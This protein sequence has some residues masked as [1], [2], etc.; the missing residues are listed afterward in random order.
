MK[1]WFANLSKGL[2]VKVNNTPTEKEGLSTTNSSALTNTYSIT[3]PAEETI[4]TDVLT[5]NYSYPQNKTFFFVDVETATSANDTICAI[6]SI[7]V[8]D[9][10]V[11][12]LYSLINPKTHITNTSIHGIA[13][14]DVHDAPTFDKYWPTI[15]RLIG[16]DFIV[17]GHNVSFDISVIN[18]NLNE[19]GIAFTP[20]MKVDTMAVAK[21]V[22]YNFSTQSG[23]LKLNM[24]CKRLNIS[25]KHHNAESDIAATKQALETLL[26]MGGRSI[27]D[28]I[29]LHHMSR[30]DNVI[31]N[32]KKLS[33][34]RYWEDIH[35]G[36]TPVYFTNWNNTYYDSNPKYDEVELDVLQFASMM[37]R[38]NC[39]IPRVV[40]QV[41]LI[42]SCI[43]S[44]CGKVYGKGAKTAKCYIEFYYMDIA[45]YIKLKKLGYKIYHAID[46]ENFILENK[47]TI[48]QYGEEQTKALTLAMQEK[49]RLARERNE[50]RVQRE[51]RRETKRLEPKE[52]P[53]RNTRRVEQLNDD[54]DVIAVFESI[55][56]AVKTTGTNSKSIRDCCNGIQ[57][58][59]GG[60]VW[61]YLDNDKTN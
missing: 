4:T 27:T 34:N 52:S 13:D 33:P 48:Q 9:G 44:I 59:A 39:N 46:V 6:G 31:G 20:T 28:F 58:H 1:K 51:A 5:S 11:T 60:F 10:N 42:K 55:S 49:E 32:V 24:I 3:N 21:D 26:V 36:R 29:N 16:N 54:G 22:L 15:S 19:Y 56:E 40:K 2:F 8:K 37:D 53:K 35:V 18:K 41:E 57:K 25:L 30:R 14:G 38:S 7:I 12:N 45:E 50:R 47:E 23:D 17:V 43:N 61:K